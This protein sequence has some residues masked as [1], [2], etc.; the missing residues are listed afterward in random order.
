MNLDGELADA[1]DVSPSQ[2][3]RKRRKGSDMVIVAGVKYPLLC[4]PKSKVWS[5]RK[6]TKE[7]AIYHNL[8]V[9][10][11]D[12]A[13]E[14]AVE[15][16]AKHAGEKRR[17]STG[18]ATLKE[19]FEAY[20]AMPKRVSEPV[21]EMNIARCR[22]IVNAAWKKAPEDVLGSD[23]SGQLWED[24]AAVKQGGKL[25]LSTRT[26]ENRG[27]NA[28]IRCAVS[29]F[30]EGLERGYEKAGIVLDFGAIRRVQWL[31]EIP[32]KIPK[33]D[34]DSEKNM[35]EALPALL[36]KDP[37]KWRAIMLARYAGLRAKEIRFARKSWLE[38]RNGAVGI[39][40]S[41]RPEEGF[42]HKTGADYFA[43]ILSSELVADLEALPDGLL[44]PVQGSPD[45]FYKHACNAWLRKFIPLP[46]K[47]LHRLRALYLDHMKAA[48]ASQ[49]L[50]EQEGIK[51]AQGA[52]GHT[53]SRTTT[54][55]YLSGPTIIR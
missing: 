17:L 29:I 41:D 34:P 7:S 12:T 46:N 47:G 11:R 6:R 37:L 24:Y 53:S 32:K 3:K 55:H 26:H 1:L 44:V 22:I 16:L 21:A 18:G 4:D 5:I 35:L 36:A 27:I 8:K 39:S 10:D 40:I 13:K 45:H 19:I 9:A 15:W 42:M 48:M 2:K 28:A 43:P 14:K 33:L 50:A 25:D 49:I 52:A 38:K 23:L 20:R 54:K 31:P 51:A 30:H